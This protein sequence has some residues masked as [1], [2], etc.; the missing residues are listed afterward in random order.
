MLLFRKNMLASDT[1][2]RRMIFFSDVDAPST[3]VPEEPEA[4]ETIDAFEPLDD[5]GEVSPDVVSD[6]AVSESDRRIEEA[7]Q[8]LDD[9]QNRVD[10]VDPDKMT[11]ERLQDEL[12][13]DKKVVEQEVAQLDEKMESKKKEIAFL[14]GEAKPLLERGE[15]LS[16]D[17]QTRLNQLEAQIKENLDA[18][19]KMDKEKTEKAASLFEKE[20]DLREPP[21]DYAEAL[22]QAAWEMRNDPSGPLGGAVK[23]IGI[24]IAMMSGKEFQAQQKTPSVLAKAADRKELKAK[25]DAD[26]ELTADGMKG[27]NGTKIREKNTELTTLRDVKIPEFEKKIRDTNTALVGK[28]D[29]EKT[30]LET[31][32]TE[33]Q[34]ALNQ[35]KTKIAELQKEISTLEKNN[36]TLDAWIEETANNAEKANEVL[37][38]VQTDFSGQLDSLTGMEIQVAHNQIS[39]RAKVEYPASIRNQLFE[40]F[41]M[42]DDEI[43][44]LGFMEEDGV[45]YVKNVSTLLE[46]V[47]KTLAG[48]QAS[49]SETEETPPIAEEPESGVL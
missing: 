41:G 14:Q 47:T 22:Q 10:S 40:K 36:V 28:S 20:R 49:E 17:E 45:T 6:A 3:D 29:P 19:T 43:N 23:A 12:N 13:E 4:D 8:A 34:N 25:F 27:A 26:P 39:L 44:R 16:P 35:E 2:E 42:T 18:Y 33:F 1:Q 31:Q 7:K 48:E 15:S 46:I 9:A 21:K 37:S 24:L 38:K 5:S 32:R 30:A 11:K